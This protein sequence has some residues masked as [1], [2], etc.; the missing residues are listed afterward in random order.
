VLLLFALATANGMLT[1][2]GMHIGNLHMN[3]AG[4]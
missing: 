4:H 1:H 2:V 3:W